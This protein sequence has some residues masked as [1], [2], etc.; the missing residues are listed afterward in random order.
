MPRGDRTG[1]EGMGPQSG[2]GL[3]PCGTGTEEIPEN[4]NNEGFFRRLG[5]GLGLGRAGKGRGMGQGLG[6]GQGRGQG[7][8]R[9]R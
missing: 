1:P 6:R 5:R 9:N 2:R 7:R 8:G 3:G 4:T